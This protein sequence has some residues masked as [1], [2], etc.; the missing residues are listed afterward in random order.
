M[1]CV[2]F[3]LFY[4]FVCYVCGHLSLPVDDSM[5]ITGLLSGQMSGSS[6]NSP[7]QN[8]LERFRMQQIIQKQALDLIQAKSDILDLHRKVID[9]TSELNLLQMTCGSVDI[10]QGNKPP[11]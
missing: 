6:Q 7:N 4:L 9:V 2:K 8:V 5:D 11:F 3:I 1:A 10:C